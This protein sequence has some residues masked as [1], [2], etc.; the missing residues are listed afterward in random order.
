MDAIEK[1]AFDPV[2]YAIKHSLVDF[3]VAVGKDVL[4]ALLNSGF[5]LAMSWGPDKDIEGN[6]FEYIHPQNKRFPNY[7]QTKKYRNNKTECLGD[8]DAYVFYKLLTKKIDG[9]LVKVLSIYM[10]GS[11]HTP[12]QKF[13]KEGIE[14]EILDYICK[15][16]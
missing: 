3:A 2:L 9:Q 11:N 6:R 4:E 10:N 5:E 14:A 1:Y 7:P 12:S 16:R 13:R 8:Y 15:L